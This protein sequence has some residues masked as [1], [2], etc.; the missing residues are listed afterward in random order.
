MPTRPLIISVFWVS[1]PIW[2]E[3]LH[4]FFLFG[5]IVVV[6]AAIATVAR[7]VHLEHECGM[8]TYRVVILHWFVVPTRSGLSGN[9]QFPPFCNFEYI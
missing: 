2:G 5:E 9:L 6:A 1:S 4:D 7:V 3:G 8:F